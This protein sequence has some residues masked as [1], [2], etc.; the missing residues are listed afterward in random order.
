MSGSKYLLEF[1]GNIDYKTIDTLLRN[2]K[3]NR[4]FTTLNKTTR[5]RVYAV[6]VECLENI[7]RHSGLQHETRKQEISVKMENGQVII[8]AGNPIQHGDAEKLAALLNLINNLEKEDLVS[9]YDSKINIHRHPEANGAGLGFMLLKLKS[10][11]NIEYSFEE[12]TPEISFFEIRITII[13]HYMR[14]LII[15]QT[16]NSPKV[17]FD[18]DTNRYEISG[19]SRPPDVAG[20][21]GDVLSWFD[22]YSHH[23][24]QTGDN[25]KPF[26]IDLDFEYFNSSSAKYILDFCR[27]IADARSK[28]SDITIKWHYEDDDP[29]MLETGREMSKMARFPFEYVVKDKR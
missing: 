2:L 28:G 26:I 13:Q 5:R 4:D 9:L 24:H 25:K 6:T 1:S 16:S 10:C 21:Y 19:E 22:D 7:V 18:P 29:D 17:V 23:L 15:D 8:T 11:N 12:L 27:R 3:K 14:K 20:F